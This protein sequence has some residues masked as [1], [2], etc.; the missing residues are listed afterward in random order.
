MKSVPLPPGFPASHPRELVLVGSIHQRVLELL[1]GERVR[2]GEGRKVLVAGVEEL[3][4][5]MGTTN[6]AGAED[7]D[8]GAEGEGEGDGGPNSEERKAAKR[9]T[10]SEQAI[11]PEV[12][13]NPAKALIH[14]STDPRGEN[15][16]GYIRGHTVPTR[17]FLFAPELC[18]DPAFADD[19]GGMCLPAALEWDIVRE[20]D[21][22]RVRSRTAIPRQD[23]TLRLL[24]SVGV[25]KRGGAVGGDAEGRVAGSVGGGVGSDGVAVGGNAAQAGGGRGAAMAVA[26]E[27]AGERGGEDTPRGELIAWAFLGPDGSLTTLHVEP[28]FRG[29]GL[30]KMLTRRL[31]GLLAPSRS[32]SPQLPSP[33]PALPATSAHSP[34]EARPSATARPTR[35]TPHDTRTNASSLPSKVNECRPGQD[36]IPRSGFRVLRP[37]EEWAH[38]DVY[39]DNVESAGVARSL[40]G[41]EG[42]WVFWA[43]LD[44]EG[45]RV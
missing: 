29:Q 17:K 44:L 41:R 39:I 20:A 9:N 21:Y 11:I 26:S 3:G 33:S 23:R 6:G 34:T 2:E 4:G 30:A 1:K 7:G 12:E 45:L 38:S 37:G 5:S 25:R 15:A 19:A 27:E 32:P 24:G 40:G 43:W 36:G 8:G 42:W 35:E 31:F 28:A 22:A 14:G 10:N 16:R 18:T 13:A